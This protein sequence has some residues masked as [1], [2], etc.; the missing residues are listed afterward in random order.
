MDGVFDE[1]DCIADRN[2]C[3]LISPVSFSCGN[4]VPAALKSSQN[5]T[6]LGRTSGGGS[7]VVQ[8]LST[9]YGTSFQISGRLRLSFLKNGSFYDIDQGVDPDYYIDDLSHY[10]DRAALTDFING[11]Y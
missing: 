10:Y 4:L 1:E 6:L 7:C 11:L 5:V 9:A 2:L 3:C 8:P